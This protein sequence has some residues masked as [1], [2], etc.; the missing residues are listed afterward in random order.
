MFRGY[1]DRL[2]T[3]CAFNHVKTR[4]P[5]LGFG[6]WPIRF[7]D[8]AVSCAN[9]ECLIQPGQTVARDSDSLAVHFGNPRFDI[10][11]LGIVRFRRRIGAYEHQ[12]SHHRSFP[13]PLRRGIHALSLRPCL[14][15]TSNRTAAS[16]IDKKL[17]PTRVRGGIRG[18]V[19]RRD[20]HGEPALYFR[21]P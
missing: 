13:P 5:L 10:V 18:A 14:L 20:G 17:W 3:V 16:K 19:A 4:Y 9:R 8:L 15:S 21:L 11:L 6:E 12:V 7:Q 2:I 1:L